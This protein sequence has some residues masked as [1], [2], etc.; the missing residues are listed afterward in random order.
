MKSI[1]LTIF[2]S[3]IV[4]GFVGDCLMFSIGRASDLPFLIAASLVGFPLS[5]LMTYLQI[6]T[7]KNKGRI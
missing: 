5:A 1:V 2:L 7:L 6:R 4:F 3:Y